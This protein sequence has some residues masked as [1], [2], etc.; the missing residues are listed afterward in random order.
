M[1]DVKETVGCGAVSL[2]AMEFTGRIFFNFD[3]FDVWRIYATA[4]KAS[5][6][7]NVRVDVTWEEFLVEDLDPAGPIPAKTR[8]LG[9]CAAVR[10]AH[11][12]EHQRFAQALLT[13]IYEEKDD[14]KKDATLAVAARV[15]GLDE[16]EVIARAIDPG[17]ELLVATSEQARQIGVRD[18]PTIVGDGPPLYVKTTG[19]ANYG[20]AVLRLDLI[21]RMLQDDG[22]WTMAKPPTGG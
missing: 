14:P 20:S 21:N 1:F 22:I 19:A 16:D 12:D 4:L 3:T 8:A 10:Q 15:A 5:R 17:I 7:R 2:R 18:V 11:P 6:D 9:A 13:L